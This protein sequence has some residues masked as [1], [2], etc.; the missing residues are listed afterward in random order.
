MTGYGRGE[1][2][3]GTVTVLVELKTV[4]NRF[5]DVQLR[6]PR[7][8]G[9]LEPRIQAALKEAVARGRLEA[10]VRRTSEEGASQVVAD[11]GLVEHYR[12]AIAEIARRVGR[13]AAEVPLATLVTLPGVLTATEADPDVLGEWDLVE[14]ALDAAV[15]ELT[16]FRDAEGAA[17]A[18]DLLRHLDELERLRV[19]VAAQADG[20]AERVRGRLE[21]RLRKLTTERVDP[22]RLAQEVALLADKADIAEELARLASHVEQFRQAAEAG[23]PVGRKLDF[24]LQEMNREINTMGSKAAEH[25]IASLVVGMKTVLERLRE[26]AQNV[27]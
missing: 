24:L 13:D 1:A 5:R 7:E 22:T 9:V 3:N 6:T 19:E 10:S 21:E 2:S 14:A 12:R 23:E 25:T 20:V 16:A 26:Q 17:L 15:T 8:Y 27:E 18:A 11:V 4:N